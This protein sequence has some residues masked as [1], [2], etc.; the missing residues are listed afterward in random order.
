MNIKLPITVPAE[1]VSALQRIGNTDYSDLVTVFH[2]IQLHHDLWVG[3]A[4]DGGNGAYEWFV[5]S[6]GKLTTSNAGYG[7]SAIALRDVLQKEAQ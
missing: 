5:W 3:V 6:D 1:I 2:C 7:D 4:G